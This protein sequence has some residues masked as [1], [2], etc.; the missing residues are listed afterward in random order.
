[1]NSSRPYLLRALSE[2]IVD[3]QMTPHVIVDTSVSGVQVPKHFVQ[4]DRITLNISPNAVQ[5]LV[6]GNEELS[7]SAR[8]SGKAFTVIVPAS[9]VLAIFSRE[10]GQG[11]MFGS[12]PGSS[13]YQ[14]HSDEV[15]H[16]DAP[17]K[18]NAEPSGSDSFS[19]KIS[20]A[21]P[22]KKSPGLRIVK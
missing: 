14:T 10:T 21:V 22:R 20:K 13:A 7:F 18:N 4:D 9:S 1:M 8:F 15:D 3:N 19:P 17:E 11:M 6:M 5:H 12:E 2:W 16:L